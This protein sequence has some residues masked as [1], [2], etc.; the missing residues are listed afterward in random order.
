MATIENQPCPVCNS[1]TLTLTE[2]DSEVPFF[3]KI[4]LFSMRCHSCKYAKADVEMET[5]QKPNKVRFT[6][7]NKN[8]LNVRVIRSSTATITIPHVGSLQ[9]GENAEGFVSNVEGVIERFKKQIEH[10]KEATN[11]VKEKKKAKNLLKKLQKVLQGEET[12]TITLKDSAGNSGIV[13]EKAVV[14]P[15]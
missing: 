4:L 3:G 14:T 11:D 15:L 6:V 9:P 7:E 2:E 10:L 12:L 1:K 5:S 8:D 13:S